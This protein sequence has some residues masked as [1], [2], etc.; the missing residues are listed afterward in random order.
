MIDLEKV[1]IKVDGDDIYIYI[2]PSLF[3]FS[4]VSS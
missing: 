3:R 1:E 2:L 4:L